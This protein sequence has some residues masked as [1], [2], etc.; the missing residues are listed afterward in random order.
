MAAHTRDITVKPTAATLD[1]NPYFDF[2]R[3]HRLRHVVNAKFLSY[4]R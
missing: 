3:Y 4:I 2:L 1:Y